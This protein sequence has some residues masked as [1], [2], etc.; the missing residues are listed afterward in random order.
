MIGHDLT[1][2]E[3]YG[4]RLFGIDA[5]EEQPEQPR[6]TTVLLVHVDLAALEQAQRDV[7]LVADV[8]G[9]LFARLNR[10]LRRLRTRVY[11]TPE[12]SQ[13]HAAYRAKTRRRHR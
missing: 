9:R 4:R 13:M 12:R 7:A 2:M 11:E 3:A 5:P 1:P 6:T 10:R 8:A